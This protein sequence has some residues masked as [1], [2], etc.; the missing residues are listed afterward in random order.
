MR[1]ETSEMSLF[2]TVF[3]LHKPRGFSACVLGMFC[4]FLVR[5]FGG[6]GCYLKVA[7]EGIVVH[8]AGAVNYKLN[9]YSLVC[10][11]FFSERK[12]LRS[13]KIVVSNP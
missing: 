9:R 10:R 13:Y 5:P 2:I 11:C 8:R 6:I 12:D 3:F 4:L 1:N 7:G